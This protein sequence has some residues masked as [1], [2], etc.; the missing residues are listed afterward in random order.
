MET[1]WKSTQILAWII[2]AM[3]WYFSDTTELKQRVAVAETRIEQE[4]L[5]YRVVQNE[6]SRRL[7]RLEDKLDRALDLRRSN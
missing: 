3:A 2:A 4:T 6:L 5:G 1:F 7:E